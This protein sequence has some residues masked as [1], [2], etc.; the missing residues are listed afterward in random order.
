[1]SNLKGGHEQNGKIYCRTL[2]PSWKYVSFLSEM[3]KK[4]ETN[5]CNNAI[6][7]FE[8]KTKSKVEYS[9]HIPEADLKLILQGKDPKL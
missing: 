7:S 9:P 1:V 4:T 8:K 3:A 5:S 6:K 2:E